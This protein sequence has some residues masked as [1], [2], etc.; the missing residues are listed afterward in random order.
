MS[1]W[2][3]K[4]ASNKKSAIH[5]AGFDVM[6]PTGFSNVDYVNGTTVHVR[7]ENINIDYE[8]VGIV[9]GTS[10]TIISRPGSGKS[11]LVTQWIGN[12]LR[13][14][15]DS[16]A[17]IDD[18]EGSLPAPRK[19]Y[20]LGLSKKDINERV[21]IRNDGITTENVYE[22]IRFIRDTKRANQ[23]EL[24][25]DTGLY[26]TD[27][28]RIFKFIPT[29]YFIDSFAMLL[30]EDVN[31]DEEMEASKN[32][33]MSLAKKNTSFI[34]KIGQLLKEAN[35]VF[36]TINHI[37]DDVQMGPFST[38]VQ[39]EG[40]KKGERLPGGKTALYLANNMFRLDKTKTLKEEEMFKIAGS[41]VDFTIC[42]SR[43]NANL[44]SVPLVFDKSRGLFDNELSVFYYLKENGYIAGTGRG[45][46]IDGY[47]E[48]KFSQADFKTRLF[49]SPELQSIFVEVAHEALS[50]LLSNTRTEEAQLNSF[51]LSKAIL[52]KV[53]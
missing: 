39:V 10:N 30:P 22:Q 36:F 49:E 23:T 25:Y 15:P 1:I 50:K 42:K 18:I 53:S 8:A 21:F 47:P 11:T 19:E 34:K 24:Q 28:N 27:G 35:I 3:E 38:P 52:A 12:L 29:F 16:E 33:A 6:Y 51:D 20:L 4:L 48:Y 9:D 5:E 46:Y 17:Y 32:Q 41:V 43:T 31:E 2:R 37:Q 44:R 14:Y 26:D 45:M 13:S 7:S 40:L